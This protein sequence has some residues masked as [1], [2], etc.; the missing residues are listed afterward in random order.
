M[1]GKISD[2]IKLMNTY[3]N[4]NK[5]K[6]NIEKTQILLSGNNVK[7]RGNIVIEDKIIYNKSNMKILGTI[8]SEDAKFNNHLTFGTNSLLTQLKRR[9]AAISRIAKPF[10]LKFKVQL[11]HALLIGKIRYNIQTWGNI[12]VEL[13]YKINK[14]ISKMVDKITNNIWFGRDS[15]WRMKKL[16]IPTFY[17]IFYDSSYIQ[18]YKFLNQDKTNAMYFILTKD[19]NINLLAQNKCCTFNHDE[20]PSY[21]TKLSFESNMRIKYNL[22]PRAITLSPN[23]NLFKKWL[24]KY[25]DMTEFE[26]YPVRKD[27]NITSVPVI[28]HQKLLFCSSIV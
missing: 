7:L 24:H 17:R 22:L 15:K 2:Y 4:S 11:V 6:I 25:H 12:S 8:Y 13:K 1:F 3:Y 14:I 27:N 5:L 16:K 18:T 21:L 10:D 9:S 20:N 23:V 26:C 28:S 19:R